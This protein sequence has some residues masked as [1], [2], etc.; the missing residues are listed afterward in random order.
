MKT[1]MKRTIELAAAAREAIH[2]LEE[3]LLSEWKDAADGFDHFADD[4]HQMWSYAEEVKSAM[5]RFRREMRR[6]MG[7][8]ERVKQP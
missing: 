3:H 6:Q 2:A 1:D 7:P 4:K 5:Y 8:V